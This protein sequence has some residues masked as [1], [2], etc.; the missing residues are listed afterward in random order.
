MNGVTGA[1]AATSPVSAAW[2]KRYPLP[3]SFIT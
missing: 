1:F 3:A 2:L